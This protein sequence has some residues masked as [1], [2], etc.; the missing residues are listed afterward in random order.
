MGIYDK[1]GVLAA[2]E[3]EPYKLWENYSSTYIV[4][5][6]YNAPNGVMPWTTSHIVIDDPDYR[7]HTTQESTMPPVQ[8][9]TLFKFITEKPAADVIW[10]TLLD[11]DIKPNSGYTDIQIR[12]M[13]YVILQY[14]DFKASKDLCN[15]FLSGKP[16]GLAT[17]FNT[18]IPNKADAVKDIKPI[19]IG[20][21]NWI[22]TKLYTPYYISYV[23]LRANSDL[24]LDLFDRDSISGDEVGFIKASIEDAYSDSFTIY[25]LNMENY[26]PVYAQF[27][28]IFKHDPYL[29]PVQVASKDKFHQ[30][31]KSLIFDYL[32]DGTVFDYSTRI[33][34]PPIT[35]VERTSD[36]AQ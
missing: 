27:S 13:M 6:N 14:G 3:K 20:L 10:E 36:E 15:S 12:Y 31:L 22:D 34:I 4:T 5:K 26:D 2:Q 1:L 17:A 8:K 19:T 29:E 25:N 32:E 16:A 23:L 7:K 35:L 28:R 9:Q 21:P 11:A 33:S 18:I 24:W 30:Y